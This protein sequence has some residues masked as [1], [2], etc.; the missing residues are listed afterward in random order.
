MSEQ[1]KT[2][3][4]ETEGKFPVR[5][6]DKCVYCGG[7]AEAVYNLRTS[8]KR[9]RRTKYVTWKIPYCNA[10]AQARKKYAKKLGMTGLMI[11]ITLVLGF[12]VIGVMGSVNIKGGL[13][14]PVGIA[15]GYA[16]AAMIRTQLRNRMMSKD[17]DLAEMY[18]ARNLGFN[19]FQGWSSA[20]FTFTN[21]VFAEE[22]AK[23]NETA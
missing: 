9:S 19:V 6:P 20:E 22:F 1:I 23:Q 3:I 13:V 17:S 21:K 5:M 2:T 14:F 12:L 11:V 10:H 8:A 18:D 4:K 7:P 16:G 15:L